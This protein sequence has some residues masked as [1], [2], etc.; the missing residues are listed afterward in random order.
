MPRPRVTFSRNGTTS[1]GFSGPPKETSRRASYGAD[2]GHVASLG[3][4]RETDWPGVPGWSYLGGDHGVPVLLPRGPLPSRCAEVLAD[5][6][7]RRGCRSRHGRPRASCCW[8]RPRP[9]PT[10][11]PE[12][13]PRRYI[14]AN[15]VLAMPMG[16]LV[17]RLGPGPGARPR[18]ASGLGAAMVAADRDRSRPTGRSRSTYVAAA[19]A[20]AALPPDRRRASAPAGPTSSTSRT[21]SQTA[22]ALE[23]VVD[24]VGLH[25]SARS[26]SRCSR[27]LIH[28]VARH[29]DGDRRPVWSAA[30][31]SRP[32]AAPSRPPHPQ[33][34]LAGVRGP[35]LPWRTVV[36]ARR[37]L[38]RARHPVRRRRGDHRRVRRRAGPQ[39]CGR[40][41]AG[42]LGARQPP[43]RR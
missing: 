10:A 38:R 2:V 31:P 30:W 33:R 5:R 20:G 8:S 13:S 11:W 28:P 17:D 42:G 40:R 12:P 19:L 32:S 7:R 24:E 16:R 35:P 3:A 14:V 37:R 41:T 9:T 26:W 39:V 15:A 43:R 27:P 21:R 36:P 29:R 1:S 6:S 22:Y 23:A 34:P 4:A 18:P 25:R